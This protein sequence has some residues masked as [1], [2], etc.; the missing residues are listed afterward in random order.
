MFRNY[1][2]VLW[3][4][5]RCLDECLCV[6]CDC[7]VYLLRPLLCYTFCVWMIRLLV[8]FGLDFNWCW[9]ACW[10]FCLVVCGVFIMV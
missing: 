2:F 7:V 1:G 4:G 8:L 9:F 10:L 3:V 5:L 6:D